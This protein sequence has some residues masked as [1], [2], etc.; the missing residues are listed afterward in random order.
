MRNRDDMPVIELVAFLLRIC[1]RHAGDLHRAW[2]KQYAAD[3]NPAPY[4]EE[5]ELKIGA[6]KDV[7]DPEYALSG[8]LGWVADLLDAATDTED[9]ALR[10]RDTA[11]VL[12]AKRGHLFFDWFAGQRSRR[13]PGDPVPV[14][15]E[16]V[17][18]EQLG[19]ASGLSPLPDGSEVPP[20]IGVPVDGTKRLRLCPEGVDKLS[21]HFDAR[22]HRQVDHLFS[23]DH[24]EPPGPHVVWAAV[25]PS[26]S[27]LRD[28]D[29]DL[30]DDKTPKAFYRVRPREPSEDYRGRIR[31]G[32]EIAAREGARIV[33]L[34][35]LSTDARLEAE[36]AAWFETNRSVRLLVAGS[37]HLDGPDEPRR[38]RARVLMRG[39]APSELLTHDKYS[40]FTIDFAGADR[41]EDIERPSEL[42]LVSGRRWSFSPLICKDFIEGTTRRLLCDLRARVVMIASMSP[43]TELYEVQAKGLAQD[44][45]AI[46]FVSNAPHGREDV[47]AVL[48]RP[49]WK[50]EPATAKQVKGGV[51]AFTR[52]SEDNFK[53]IPIS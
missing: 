11:T 9:L 18:V 24:V 22:F 33:M 3:A 36:L 35:E 39:L 37:R 4:L 27:I 53:I 21:V 7:L 50:P 2:E 29:V 5:V 8:V 23:P 52:L 12:D 17:I 45:Q 28:L 25:V 44:A 20:W 51:V 14:P 46:V 30:I 13:L 40:Y 48:A 6:A 10:A 34:P 15:P 26:C 47:T 16:E 49:L 41:L 31:K 32:L 43:K 19:T 38:N 1:R 42:S